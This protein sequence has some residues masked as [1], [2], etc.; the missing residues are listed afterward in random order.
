MIRIAVNVHDLNQWYTISRDIDTKT[1]DCGLKQ[2]NGGSQGG[3]TAWKWAQNSH[4]HNYVHNLCMIYVINKTEWILSLGLLSFTWI[5]LIM[6]AFCLLLSYDNQAVVE[7]VNSGYNK[8]LDMSHLLCCLF[9]IL[10]TSEISLVATHIQGKSNIRADAILWDNLQL[11]H[12]QALEADWSPTL[13]PESVVDLLI[14]QKPDWTSRAW[15]Q[16]FT[17]SWEQV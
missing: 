9:F 2:F 11:F 12:L 14:C 16:L 7:V 10:A 5:C 6:P 17:S 1:I 4:E 15:C 8:D 3:Y 13:A